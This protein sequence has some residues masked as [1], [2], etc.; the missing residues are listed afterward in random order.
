METLEDAKSE[1]EALLATAPTKPILLHHAIVIGLNFLST[2]LTDVSMSLG[3]SPQMKAFTDDNSL[4]MDLAMEAI[5]VVKDL[6][7]LI[8]GRLMPS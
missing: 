1:R 3:S 4:W 7:V 5:F 6:Y 2:T 8:F